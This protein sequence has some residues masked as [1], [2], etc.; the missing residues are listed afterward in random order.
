MKRLLC[1]LVL[2]T[3][4]F[5]LFSQTTESASGA[6][7]S[8]TASVIRNVGVKSIDFTCPDTSYLE[9][10]DQF[11]NMIKS[12]VPESNRLVCAF[13]TRADVA[14]LEEGKDP[15]MDKYILVEVSNAAENQDC[16]PADFK[17]VKSSMSDITSGLSDKGSDMM[18]EINN[19]LK[20]MDLGGV[21]L[22]DPVDLGVLFNKE[23]AAASGMLFKVSQAESVKTYIASIL[24]IRLKERLIF[25]YIYKTYNGESTVKEITSFTDE[26][27]TALLTA[28]PPAKGEFFSDLWEGLPRWAKGAIIGAILGL[29][30]SLFKSIGKT[31]K[32]V[33]PEQAPAETETT[34]DEP[35]EEPE[36]KEE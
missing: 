1:L 6:A 28:N 27:T 2:L 32:V 13:L 24:L 20:A 10:S 17:E 16:K 19:K 3:N 14:K 18:T 15:D 33:E 26:Y 8:S 22:N 31:Q 9:V 4:G 12:F 34:G 23:D 11:Y 36:N 7:G 5:V 25:V 30:Y 21:Q 29:L 35:G